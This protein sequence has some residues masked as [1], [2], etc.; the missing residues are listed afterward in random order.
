MADTQAQ[1]LAS[2]TDA[3]PNGAVP[4][5]VPRTHMAS[6]I[7]ARA[8]LPQGETKVEIKN[9][10]FFYGKFQALKGISLPLYDR[11]V[12]AFIGPSGCGKSTLLRVLNRIYTLY[13]GQRATGEVIL[14]GQNI[15]EPGI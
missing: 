7:P 10:D 6:A 4:R 12:T 15:L 2:R 3:S 9:L 1:A 14:D 8:P 11:R 13:P 5:A